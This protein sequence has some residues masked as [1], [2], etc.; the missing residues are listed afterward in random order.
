MIELSLTSQ[1]SLCG[2]EIVQVKRERVIRQHMNQLIQLGVIVILLCGLEGYLH[3]F[4]PKYCNLVDAEA[5]FTRQKKKLALSYKN[6]RKISK[7]TKV[8][9]VPPPRFGTIQGPKRK[10]SH[11]I[12]Y[13]MFLL[14]PSTAFQWIHERVSSV[15]QILCEP[16]WKL[17]SFLSS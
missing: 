3:V 9:S 15:S 8:N 7:D 2:Q 6:L 4:L 10:S 17:I 16:S 14:S 5:L 13:G 12:I 1:N 11:R